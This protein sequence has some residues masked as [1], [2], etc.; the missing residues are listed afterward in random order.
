VAADLLCW[1]HEQ[2][3]TLDELRQQYLD[4]W[5]AAGRSTRALR[6]GVF[7]ACARRGRLVD[8]LDASI[9]H[10]PAAARADDAER[11]F[12]I[13]Q[14]LLRDR[15]LD[16]RDRLAGALV[17]LFAQPITRMLQLSPEHIEVHD[18]VVRLRLGR[19]PLEL[20]EAVGSA[21][22][23]SR[24]DATGPCHDRGRGTSSVAVPWAPAR[25]AAV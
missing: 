10:K 13:L 9:G 16:P 22:G 7:L 11:R 6:I 18:K 8:A 25:R 5:I 17:L 12:D 3:V 14:R 21:R 24:R 23:R 1:L 20:P 4:E 2:D 15:E 19:D